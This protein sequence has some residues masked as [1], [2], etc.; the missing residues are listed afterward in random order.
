MNAN[1]ASALHASAPRASTLLCILSCAAILTVAFVHTPAAAAD[2]PG[3]LHLPHP[4][5]YN[6][7]AYFDLDS[8]AEWVRDWTGWQSSSWTSGHAYDGHG[9]TDWGMTYLTDVL[10]AADG[11][12]Y[13][14]S[15]GVPRDD[16]TN[17]GNYVFLRHPQT[18]GGLWDTNYFHL[19]PGV[20]SY[21]T[22]GQMVAQGEHIAESDN[23]G[24]STGAH[25]HFG[26]RPT[27]GSYSCPFYQAWWA[28]SA[29]GAS[30]V[31]VTGAGSLNVRSGPSTSYAAFTQLDDGQEFV[32]CET[33]SGWKRLFIPSE[34]R[35]P[36]CR[37]SAGTLLAPPDYVETDGGAEAWANS[38]SKSAASGTSGT[39][40]RFNDDV[41]HS[42]TA[43][44]VPDLPDAGDY[45]VFV[46]WGTSG[47][48]DN[49]KYTVNYNGGSSH[50]LLDQ[51]GWGRDGTVTDPIEIK[52][53]P[54]TDTHT[55]VGAPQDLWNTYSCSAAAEYGPERVYVLTTAVAGDIVA[56][57]DSI[58]SGVDCDV[59]I[60]SGPS[61]A[62]CLTR[63]DVTATAVAA[64]A[65][66]YYIVVDSYGAAGSENPG[67][68]SLTVTYPS[69]DGTI[70]NPF[71]IDATGY[72]H[73]YS[74]VG[75][76]QDVWDTYSCSALSVFGREVVYRLVTESAGDIRAQCITTGT[77]ADLD[78]YLLDGPSNA[79]CATRGDEQADY[80]DAPAGTYYIV[81]ESYGTAGS[82]QEGAYRLT[83]TFEGQSAAESEHGDSN[84]NQWISLG[85]FP[86]LAGQSAANG[87]ILIDES[88]VTGKPNAANAGRIYSDSV[89]FTR[90]G[91]QYTGWASGTYLPAQASS[92]PQ[93]VIRAAEAVLRASPSAA[94]PVVGRVVKGQRFIPIS[95][96]GGWFQLPLT[97]STASGWLDANPTGTAVLYGTVT[98]SV[99]AWPLY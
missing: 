80:A 65:G 73:E 67:P 79:N 44:F 89:R 7:T 55:T 70:A 6:I 40:A 96:S 54:Y 20:G 21:V 3:P 2:T 23:T 71:P 11:Q 98:S 10:A 84:A 56:T 93:M 45:E 97:G 78:V 60:L 88:T 61:N 35:L 58:G 15:D 22:N 9:G 49:L 81:V 43:Q 76:G 77:G 24:N 47:N 57:C 94:S 30:K 66:T 74:T 72:V 14:I 38:S 59:Y 69:G 4:G 92:D 82:E 99:E 51:Q 17:S 85:V 37:D 18:S 25:L 32:A 5:G 75:N 46:T 42:A 41:S 12:V 95:Q 62:N 8:S 13:S 53:N 68:Y 91:N 64:P 90:N 48:A 28:S 83:V 26:V 86:F 33:S 63:D 27:G 50:R 87:S 34:E 29:V 31:L 39:G 1:H 36:E 52:A 16:H 19:E